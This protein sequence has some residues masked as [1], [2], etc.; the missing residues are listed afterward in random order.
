M[1]YMKLSTLN[2]L[3]ALAQLPLR[4]AHL[5][6]TS[7]SDAEVVTVTL[8][9]I[10]KLITINMVQSTRPLIIRLTT[11]VHKGSIFRYCDL[12]HAALITAAIKVLAVYR[13]TSTCRMLNMRKC[14]YYVESSHLCSGVSTVSPV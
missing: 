5:T 14:A 7:S 1:D 8:Q 13:S 9:L 10:H 12:Y 2:I 11:G 3:L 4:R 6:A